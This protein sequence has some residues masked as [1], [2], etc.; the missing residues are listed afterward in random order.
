MSNIIEIYYGDLLSYIFIYI[1]KIDYIQ[2]YTVI[3]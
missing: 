2:N 3:L 1:D